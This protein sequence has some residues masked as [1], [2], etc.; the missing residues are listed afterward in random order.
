M[1]GSSA[2]TMPPLIIQLQEAAMN[3]SVKVSELLSKAKVT[4]SKLKLGQLLEWI[5]LET[6]G[7]GDRP[8]PS[9]REL[10]AEPKLVNP[11]RG[12]TPILSDDPAFMAQ[13]SVARTSQSVSEL[14]SLVSGSATHL[15]MI[16]PPRLQTYVQRNAS[17]PV[18]MQGVWLIGANQ[19][20]GALNFVR[21][22]VLDWSLELENAGVLG[23]GFTFSA[24]ERVSAMSVTNNVYGSNIGVLGNLGDQ[25][26]VSNTQQIMS[27]LPSKDQ[28]LALIEQIRASQSLL[29]PT[30]GAEVGASV[31]ILEGEMSGASPDQ[32]KIG[33]ALKSIRTVCEGAAGNLVASGIVGLISQL[34]G[35]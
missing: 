2:T 4:A 15:R 20:E 12:L 8:V 3:H 6:N 17:L 9:Y 21:Q 23:E 35:F 24:T 25:A 31:S 18:A 14:E 33:A 1:N 29:P 34:P 5:E 16:F 30:V 13:I 7:Y 11:L 10:R 26:V 19:I 22:R 32:S 27:D 28:L